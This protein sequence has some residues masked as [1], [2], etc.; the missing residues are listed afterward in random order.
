MEALWIF[1]EEWKCGK[2]FLGKAICCLFLYQ[3]WTKD[4]YQILILL[5]LLYVHSLMEL[6]CCYLDMLC[7][8][9]FSAVLQ[10]VSRHFPNSS[11][12]EAEDVAQDRRTGEELVLLIILLFC[13]CQPAHYQESQVWGRVISCLFRDLRPGF[14]EEVLCLLE[15]ITL[16]QDILLPN[17]P[18]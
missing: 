3:T 9:K 2:T 16:L 1:A 12:R 11:I 17:C 6:F 13:C 18:F 5:S 15:D 4:D 7:S 8:T 10:V 14:K